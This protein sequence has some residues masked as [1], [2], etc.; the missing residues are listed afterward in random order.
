MSGSRSAHSFENFDDPLVYA[1]HEAA[2]LQADTFNFVI[3]FDSETAL[4]TLNIDLQSMESILSTQVR[5]FITFQT[6]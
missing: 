2:V 3:D 6:A 1:K 5:H 4:S